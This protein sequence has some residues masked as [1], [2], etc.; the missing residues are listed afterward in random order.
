MFALARLCGTV[1]RLNY[2][3]AMMHFEVVA[4]IG[5]GVTNYGSTQ[6]GRSTMQISA[7]VAYLCLLLDTPL[8]SDKTVTTIAERKW[9]G[10]SPELTNRFDRRA[11]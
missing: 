9:K 7:A 1:I 3:L 2:P 11:S 4:I 10:C 8:R 5:K 6:V